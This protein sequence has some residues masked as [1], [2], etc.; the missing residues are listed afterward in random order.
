M[1]KSILAILIAMT[2]TVPSGLLL[3][4]YGETTKEYR[5]RKFSLE[6]KM[7]IRLQRLRDELA[8]FRKRR[9]LVGGLEVDIRSRQ[10]EREIADLEKNVAAR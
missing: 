1:Y 4:L 8:E 10:T 5:E 2:I 3:G 9:D 7:T 6:P